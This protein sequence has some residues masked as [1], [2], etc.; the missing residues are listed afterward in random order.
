MNEELTVAAIEIL[1][2]GIIK[3]FKLKKIKKKTWIYRFIDPK[4]KYIYKFL[5]FPFTSFQILNCYTIVYYEYLLP[6]WLA[7]T[8]LFC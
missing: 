5:Q 6:I 8:I 4:K 2:R 3:K 1:F 7:M